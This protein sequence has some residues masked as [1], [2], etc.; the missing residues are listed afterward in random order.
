MNDWSAVILF[1]IYVTRFQEVGR[2]METPLV[3]GQNVLLVWSGKQPPKQIEEIVRQLSSSVG[4]EGK[5]SV[6]HEERLSM[7]K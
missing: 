2:K 5:I 6:E 4:D 3:K 1:L 7:C